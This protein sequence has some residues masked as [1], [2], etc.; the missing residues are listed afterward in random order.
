[1]QRQLRRWRDGRIRGGR[2]P[3]V[4]GAQKKVDGWLKARHMGDLFAVKVR[5]QDG[6]PKVNYRFQRRAWEQLQRT[7]LGKTLIFSDNADWSDGELVRGYRAQ[8][9]VQSAFRQMK[10]TDSIAI[11]PQ[12][13]WTDQNI[14]EHVFCCVLALTLCG[15]LQRE[16][17]RAGICRPVQVILSELG[18]ICEVNLLYPPREAGAEPELRTTLS[19]MSAEQRCLYDA[20]GLEKY[21]SKTRTC[22]GRSY[23]GISSVPLQ[24]KAL[25]IPW[26]LT[27]QTQARPSV[28][29]QV[30]DC[31]VR[32]HALIFCRQN[33]PRVFRHLNK[34]QSRPFQKHP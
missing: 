25:S 31:H 9:R 22:P 15:L 28:R 18:G 10:D 16:L 30:A 14:R 27:R 33:S 13:H 21:L 4:A 8:H 29:G 1:M 2:K 11:R 7:L 24:E 32:R 26:N 5:E 20:L 34:W 17:S 23:R 12:H 6:L 19:Q 3:G